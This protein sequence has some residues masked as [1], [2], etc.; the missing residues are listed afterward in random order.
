MLE[1][2]PKNEILLSSEFSKRLIELIEKAKNSIHIFM[3]DW[4]W[5]KDDFSCDVSLI[6]QALVRAYRRGVEVKAL[7]NYYELLET[8]APL[9][10]KAKKANIKKL[11]H[12]KSI[13]IDNDIAIIG[14]HNLSNQAMRENVEISVVIYDKEICT[15]IKNYFDQIWRS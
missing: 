5:Y 15:R 3:F 1:T 6:N 8:L 14:S 10:I 4:R 11:L 12:A 7:L 2:I 13:V 9:G